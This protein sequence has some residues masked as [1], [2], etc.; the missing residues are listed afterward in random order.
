MINNSKYTENAQHNG[1]STYW[2]ETNYS[3]YA[4][5]QNKKTRDLK[6]ISLERIMI[7]KHLEKEKV[8]ACCTDRWNSTLYNFS[9]DTFNLNTGYF[10]DFTQFQIIPHD[11]F[12]YSLFGF[13]IEATYI[14]I[15]EQFVMSGKICQELSWNKRSSASIQNISLEIT[16]QIFQTSWMWKFII[17]SCTN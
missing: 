16:S 3:Y 1:R 12:I 7:I 14:R 17:R 15:N 2:K 13:N 11:C 8:H 6:K 9:L 5:D 10:A 4:V